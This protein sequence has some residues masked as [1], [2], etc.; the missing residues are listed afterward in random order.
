MMNLQ[1]LKRI[2]IIV[3]G[4]LFA[5]TA[6]SASF[7]SPRQIVLPTAQTA[8]ASGDLNNDGFPDMIVGGDPTSNTSLGKIYVF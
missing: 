7:N 6:N 2:R 4:S 3:V 5:V 8:V 1:L